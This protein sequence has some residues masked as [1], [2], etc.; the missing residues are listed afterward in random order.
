MSPVDAKRR[1]AR[2]GLVM[3]T[4]A[5]FAAASCGR[6]SSPASISPS[7]TPRACDVPVYVPVPSM[8]WSCPPVAAVR[9]METELDIVFEQDP[10]VGAAACGAADGSLELTRLQE[11]VFQALYLMRR[12]RFDAPLPWTSE[13]LWSWF[14][15]EV[16]G[17]RVGGSRTYCCPSPGV[18]V[19]AVSS[20]Y[21]S[22]FPTLIEGLVHEARHIDGQHPH[23]CGTGAD[24]SIAELG[25]YGVQYYLN[26]WLARHTVEPALSVEERQYCASRADFMR[27]YSFCQECGGTARA[28]LAPHRSSYRPGFIPA[29][30]APHPVP[31]GL[32]RGGR[33]SRTASPTARRPSRTE[34]RL[35]R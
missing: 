32:R 31:R 11:R 18:I 3:T 21:G 35:R 28:A 1:T 16:R 10:T 9:A 17:I 6:A 13:T 4:V 23:S 27:Y 12:L 24:Q 26:L 14:T 19:I 34:D 15:G 8:P 2:L 22:G 20:E 25:A 7:G 30:G 29:A 5:A 33:R